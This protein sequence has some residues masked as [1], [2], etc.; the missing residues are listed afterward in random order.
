L[1]FIPEVCCPPEPVNRKNAGVADAAGCKVVSLKNAYDVG[2]AFKRIGL[3][4]ILA[5]LAMYQLPLFA[6]S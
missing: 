3:G 2:M 1:P 4:G 6:S 5:D